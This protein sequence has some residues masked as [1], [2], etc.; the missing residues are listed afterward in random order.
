[1]NEI[2]AVG[3]GHE[4]GVLD[5]YLCTLTVVLSSLKKAVP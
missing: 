3:E 1:M 4:R 5:E 2:E